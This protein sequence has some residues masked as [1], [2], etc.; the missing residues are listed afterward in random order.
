MRVRHLGP[1]PGRT[2][3][4]TGTA[5]RPAVLRLPGPNTGAAAGGRLLGL[6]PGGG[7]AENRTA[8]GSGRG[9][10]ENPHPSPGPPGGRHLPS[11]QGRW[12]VHPGRR[13]DPGA[14]RE[15]ARPL[16]ASSNPPTTSETRDVPDAA[17]QHLQK[18]T[19]GLPPRTCRLNRPLDS[20][21]K[22]PTLQMKSPAVAARTFATRCLR[23]AVGV[24]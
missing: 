8:P 24:W 14:V 12:G 13:G 7:P 22:C 10:P 4:G 16:K 17:S 1:D 19:N 18:T 11:G 3:A 20:P 15:L 2:P 9:L 21:H 6:H 23:L 5:R